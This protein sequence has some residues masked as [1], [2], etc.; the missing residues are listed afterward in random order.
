MMHRD[1]VQRSVLAVDV[2]DELRH[3]AL[4][5]RR[6]RERG[7]RDLDEDDVADPLRVVL[8]QFLECAQLLHDTLDSVELV[9]PND[10]LLA[11]VQRTQGLE[12][13]LDTRAEPAAEALISLSQ[14]YWGKM[15]V[16]TCPS[17]RDRHRR[18]QGSS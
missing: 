8:Q 1:E 12:L 3:L 18:L 2:R 5:L 6:V 13:R 16:R 10:D 15:R 9:P 4:E 17:P 14:S 7:R 11:L